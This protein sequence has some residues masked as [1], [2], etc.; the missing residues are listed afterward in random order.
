MEIHSLFSKYKTPFLSSKILRK[1]IL[2]THLTKSQ[3]ASLGHDIPVAILV[4]T[5]SVNV[6]K[7]LAISN[8]NLSENRKKCDEF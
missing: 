7:P 6:Q 1:K 5:P 2:K 3:T 8:I 4:S